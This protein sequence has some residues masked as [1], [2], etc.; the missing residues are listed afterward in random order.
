MH[1]SVPRRPD[2]AGH[3][4]RVAAVAEGAV[5]RRL[6]RLRVEQVDQ[7]AGQDG[8]VRARH[9]KKDGQG[10][11]RVPGSPPRARSW[12]SRQ[13]P[14]LPDL[15]RGRS[16]PP[17]ITSLLD[18]G[19]L[20]QLRVERHAAGRVE[21]GVERVAGEVAGHLAVLRAHGGFRPS[22]KSASTRRSPR[23]S[24]SRRRARATWREQ[25]RLR[26]RRGTSAGC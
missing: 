25:L 6:A 14:R 9:V 1:T 26:R 5:H 22:R 10:S 18:P 4:P 21:L 20:D 12:S 23:A 16:L 3:E 24:R 2:P 8:D 7:L 11:L 17:T 15:A 13:R 19:V